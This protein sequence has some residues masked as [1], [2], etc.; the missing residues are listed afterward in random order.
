MSE[1][2]LWRRKKQK[3]IIEFFYFSLFCLEGFTAEARSSLEK[4]VE[5]IENGHFSHLKSQQTVWIRSNWLIK[6]ESSIRGKSL[7]AE[8]LKSERVKWDFNPFHRRNPA[9]LYQIFPAQTGKSSW[10]S[11]KNMCTGKRAFE[12]LPPE[13]WFNCFLLIECFSWFL[14][15]NSVLFS[16]TQTWKYKQYLF[17]FAAKVLAEKFW[18]IP[19]DHHQNLFKRAKI[20]DFLLPVFPKCW[21]MGES[22]PWDRY[23]FLSE[24]QHL[25]RVIGIAT[26]RKPWRQATN[27][28]LYHFA[29]V[30]LYFCTSFQR[31]WNSNRQRI[32]RWSLTTSLRCKMQCLTM[33]NLNSTVLLYFFAFTAPFCFFDIVPLYYSV[34]IINGIIIVLAAVD[35]PAEPFVDSPTCDPPQGILLLLAWAYVHILDNKLWNIVKILDF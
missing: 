18:N 15:W 1:T 9:S 5:E 19:R 30:S 13:R 28:P 26:D 7:F 35:S 34:N 16:P 8:N 3:K 24:S 2:S 31:D 12:K 32:C 14:A 22:T 6:A 17:F 25:F 4:E 11:D 33:Q 29:T 27:V 21:K 10:R 23:Q 20:P